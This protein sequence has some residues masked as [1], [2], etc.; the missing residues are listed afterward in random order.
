MDAL[1]H[2]GNRNFMRRKDIRKY[3]SRLPIMRQFFSASMRLIMFFWYKRLRIT[4][5]DYPDALAHHPALYLTFHENL[6]VMSF[7]IK[8]EMESHRRAVYVLSSTHPDSR[9]FVKLYQYYGPQ[10]ILGS[11]T[12]GATAAVKQLIQYIQTKQASTIITPDGPRG[13]V[14]E[15][16]K[17]ALY[18]AMKTGIPI[19]PMGIALKKYHRIKSWDRMK[20][21][22]FAW[23]NELHIF[24]GKPVFISAK[25]SK[26]E[27]EKTRLELQEKLHAYGKQAEIL[28]SQKA[29]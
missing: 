12:R 8:P 7:I 1:K 5:H 22:K 20:L 2:G 17:G 16:K 14:G 25:I 6:L 3:M 23:R 27:M 11:S 26:P 10:T 29:E 4:H 24:W 18:I 9:F 21:P 15:V 13:P 19:F 28:A